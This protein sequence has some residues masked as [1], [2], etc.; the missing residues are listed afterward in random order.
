MTERFAFTNLIE[1][2]TFDRLVDGELSATEERALLIALD[3][4]PDG[5]RRCALAFLE[6]RNWQNELGALA[7]GDCPRINGMPEGSKDL[8]PV[9]LVERHIAVKQ[10]VQP[11]QVLAVAATVAIAFLL[12]IAA[13]WQWTSSGAGARDRLAAETSKD[14]PADERIAAN[15]GDRQGVT[16]GMDYRPASTVTMSLLNGHGN[17][18]RQIEIPVVEADRLDPHWLQTT[19]SAIPDQFVEALRR[20]GH[21]VE[22][23]RLYVPIVLDDGRR[24]IVALDQARVKY[25]GVQF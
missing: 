6:S 23:Q 4:R 9:S 24:A 15:D 22:E 11:G 7:G 14:V 19:P 1:P 17:V 10:H 18:D 12:G 3:A 13:H 21:T 25:Q 8:N 2:E 5:W 16:N 20:S